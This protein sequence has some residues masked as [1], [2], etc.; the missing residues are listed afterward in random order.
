MT[1]D[2]KLE[3]FYNSSIEKATTQSI[4][5]INEYKESLKKIYDEHI[6]ESKRKAE[7]TL[8]VESD[9]L[10]REK[11]KR[12]SAQTLDI[13]REFTERTSILKESLFEDV[14]K[15]LNEFMS[16]PEYLT[17]LKKRIQTALDFAKGEEITIY[18]NPSDADKKPALEQE[19]HTTLTISNINFMG[20]I[21]AVISARNILMDYSFSTK[22]AEA[23][24]TVTLN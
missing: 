2:E 16:T 22:L 23:K 9:N 17:F 1:L 7:V 6:E 11:N 18:I 13:R 19:L 15:K 3:V 10:V 4:E 24:E 21:R 14:I 8:R 5:I 20:G 12:L